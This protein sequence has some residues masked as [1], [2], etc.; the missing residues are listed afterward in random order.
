MVRCTLCT[1]REDIGGG[2]R[3]LC[4][5][6]GST[7]YVRHGRRATTAWSAGAP[8]IRLTGCQRAVFFR[9]HFYPRKDGRAAAGESQLGI[10]LQHHAHRLASGFLG[11]LRGVKAPA[12]S[13]ELAAKTSANMLL[14][15][16]NASPRNL[17]RT[18]ILTRYAGNVLRR[19]MHQELIVGRPL[20][21]GTM[22]LHAAV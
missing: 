11:N 3:M 1:G 12:V 9:S 21:D 8:R 5:L 20:G 10:A 22:A 14:L 6:I 4:A 16:A 13:A 17:Q 7:K 19:N 15:D 2:R 18:G